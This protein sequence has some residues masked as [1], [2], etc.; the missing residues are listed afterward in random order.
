MMVVASLVP[1]F[2]M[3]ILTGAGIIV[4]MPQTQ[5]LLYLVDHTHLSAVSIQCGILLL[6]G[7]LMMTS[8]FFRLLPDLPKPVWRYPISYLSYGSWAIQVLRLIQKT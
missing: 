5:L 8:G 4:R 1:N 7:I 2:L 6:Q 3:G